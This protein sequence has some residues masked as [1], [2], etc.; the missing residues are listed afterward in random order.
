MAVTGSET[1]S[2]AA[3]RPSS[4]ATRGPIT[5]NSTSDPA[6]RSDRA[7]G[8]GGGIAV[9]GGGAGSVSW[10]KGNPRTTS[11]RMTIEKKI[12]P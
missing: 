10:R 3:A 9:D 5:A 8:A 4:P 6:A 7:I 1:R 11:S 2:P 12:Q